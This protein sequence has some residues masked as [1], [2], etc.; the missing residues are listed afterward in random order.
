MDLKILSSL[1]LGVSAVKNLELPALVIDD[2][3]QSL[4]VFLIV[5]E[6]WGNANP[7]AARAYDDIVRDQG[8]TQLT[9]IDIA[10]RREDNDSGTLVIVPRAQNDSTPLA[11]AVRKQARHFHDT[12]LDHLRPNLEQ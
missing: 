6:V 7:A 9:R 3:E 4:E 11:Q 12:L 5:V 2:R 8:F 10:R 1:R